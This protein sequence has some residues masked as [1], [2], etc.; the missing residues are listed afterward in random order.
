MQI[1]YC[2]DI[3]SGACGQWLLS[4]DIIST[5]NTYCWSRP[6]YTHTYL[7]EEATVYTYL[8]LE[9][10]TVYTYLLLEEASDCLILWLAANCCCWAR[11]S[12][13]CAVERLCWPADTII[14]KTGH[15]I[16]RQLWT[17]ILLFCTAALNCYSI[18]VR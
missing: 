2:G 11:L 1:Y 13:I 17:S 10:D 4:G 6:V 3:P 15:Y 5:I 16:K 8:L 18:S 7:L 9:E 14:Q 12:V